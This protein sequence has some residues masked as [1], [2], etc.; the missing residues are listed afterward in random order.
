MI[1]ERYNQRSTILEQCYYSQNLPLPEVPGP[2]ENR[3]PYFVDN[4]WDN[5]IRINKQISMHQLPG[6]LFNHYY[7]Y[8]ECAPLE[9]LFFQAQD[10]R[11]EVTINGSEC[12]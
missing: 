10:Q 7:I 9:R 6:V 12:R 5:I 11:T 8:R 3:G 2:V 1:A 4:D